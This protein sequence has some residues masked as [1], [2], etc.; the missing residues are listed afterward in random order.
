MMKQLFISYSRKDADFT[1]KLAERFEAEGLDTWVDWQDIPP[2]ID[3]MKE[4][5]KGIEAADIFLYLVSPDS[6]SSAVCAEELKHAI[7]NGKR[8]IPVIVRDFEFQI[9]AIGHHSL[10]L[11]LFLAFTG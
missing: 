3:W 9:G 11:D 7:A 8:I 6:I 5:Q 2:S 10:E 4:I 1:R